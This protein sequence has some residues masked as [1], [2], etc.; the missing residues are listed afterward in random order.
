[1]FILDDRFRAGQGLGPEVQLMTVPV[2]LYGPRLFVDVPRVHFHVDLDYA[3]PCSLE[4]NPVREL[5][6]RKM[7]EMSWDASPSIPPELVTRNGRRKEITIWAAHPMPRA[8]CLVS[9]SE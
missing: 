9:V 7:H 1:M 6:E 3:S 8:P 5:V 4:W 2:T